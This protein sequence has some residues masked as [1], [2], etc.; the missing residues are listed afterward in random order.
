M[1]SV[2]RAVESGQSELVEVHR[3]MLRR[4]QRELLLADRDE[5]TNSSEDFRVLKDALESMISEER[6]TGQVLRGAT[7]E[8]E[9]VDRIFA[10][11]RSNDAYTNYFVPLSSRVPVTA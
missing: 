11:D 3:F 6:I 10:N 4:K 1:L 7:M 9:T 8:E 5:R 2:Q